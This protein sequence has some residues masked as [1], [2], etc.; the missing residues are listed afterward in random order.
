VRSLFVRI[1][2]YF[3]LAMT[4]IGAIGIMV[5]FTT[6]P[7]AAWRMQHE[8]RLAHDGQKLMQAF[9]EGGVR[10]LAKLVFTLERERNVHAFLFK[11]ER[12]LLAHR[13]LPPRIQRLATLA[14][15]TGTLQYQPG[16]R[17]L[18]FA[19]ALQDGYVIVANIPPPSPLAHLFNPRHVVLRLVITFVIAGMV[20]YLLARSLTAPVR[21]LRQATQQFASGNFRTRIGL[22]LGPHAGELTDLG[23]D[24]DRMAEHIEALIRAHQRLL[25]DISHELRSPL[26]RLNVALELA[27]QGAGPAASGPLERIAREADR[28]N[29]LIGQLLT[30]S[31]L[32]SRLESPHQETFDLAQLLRDIAN[33]A[34]FEAHSRQ[35]AVRVI[36]NQA[37]TIHASRELL[38]RA[39]ENVVRNAV[40]YTPEGS[41]VSISLQHE[42]NGTERWVVIS[43]RDRGPGVPAA[44]LPHLF[45]PFYRTAEARDRL[46]GGSGIGLAIT[47]RAVQLHGGRVTAANAADGGLVVNLHLPLTSE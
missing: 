16:R 39:I 23:N 24:F 38:R 46:S 31:Q 27:R 32:E 33:D 26:A 13:L 4:L 17:G 12:E 28:L 20:C 11:D 44:A 22:A 43:V 47:A 10:E 3:W 36:A 45:E 1:F 7:Q 6:D 30:L 15:M 29:E 35:R 21:K 19:L 34:D 9:E 14:A 40:R 8:K 42:W 18:W 5:V 25:R 41:E 37:T 2:L